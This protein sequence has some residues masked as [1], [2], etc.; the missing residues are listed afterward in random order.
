MQKKFE[1]KFQKKFNIPAL[2]IEKASSIYR[3]ALEKNLIRGRSIK[4]MITAALYAAIRL[5]NNPHTLRELSEASGI[6]KGVLSKNYKLIVNKL[7]LKIPVGDPARH[8]RRICAKAGLDKKVMLEAQRIIRLAQQR[9]ITGGKDPRVIA[10]AATYYICV[11]LKIEL[12][13]KDIAKAAG[14]TEVAI[15]SR[16][17][18]LKRILAGDI[19]N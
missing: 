19:K 2:I 3:V 10:A 4:S 9:K 8:I 12:T 5:E 11:I 16:F 15:G 13:K 7:K 17:Q 14:V 1:R 6:E 18:D